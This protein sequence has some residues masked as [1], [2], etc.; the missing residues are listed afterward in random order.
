MQLNFLPTVRSERTV[1]RKCLR[2]N[3]NIFSEKKKKKTKDIN[4]IAFYEGTTFYC[5]CAVGQV[6]T[7]Y[8]EHTNIS[9][10]SAVTTCEEEL[11]LGIHNRVPCTY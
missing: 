9:H 11:A 3:T 7:H 4:I 5:G 1:V 10:T 8:V 2:S 6:R